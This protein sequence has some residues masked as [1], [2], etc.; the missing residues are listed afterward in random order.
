[1]LLELFKYLLLQFNSLSGSC[2]ITI[3]RRYETPCGVNGEIYIDGRY[4]GVTCDSFINAVELFKHVLKIG[5]EDG[6]RVLRT[7]SCILTNG[8]FT[9]KVPYNVCLIGSSE[10]HLNETALKDL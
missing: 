4:F 2:D 10:L 5:F 6:H 1:M 7:D 3:V 8:D 9:A